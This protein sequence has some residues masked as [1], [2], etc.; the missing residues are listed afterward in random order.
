VRELRTNCGHYSVYMVRKINFTCTEMY[1]KNMQSAEYSC[2]KNLVSRK[3]TYGLF[4]ETKYSN[5]VTLLLLTYLCESLSV[6][7]LNHRIGRNVREPAGDV[8][9]SRF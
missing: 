9:F 4:Q 5:G 2:L 3:E 7:R 6:N 1:L 8:S